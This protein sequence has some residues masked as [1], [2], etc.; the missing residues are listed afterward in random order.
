MKLKASKTIY[1]T[2]TNVTSNTAPLVPTI[3]QQWVDTT[4]ANPTFKEWDGESWTEVNFNI[5]KVDPE[6]I[7]SIK[8]DIQN[9]VED[10]NNSKE[11]IQSALDKSQEAIDKAGLNE[12]NIENMKTDVD[13]AIKNS[14]DA[15]SKSEQAIEESQKLSESVE[16]INTNIEK[17]DSNIGDINTNINKVNESIFDIENEMLTMGENIFPIPT[18]EGE[19]QLSKF[20]HT[21]DNDSKVFITNNDYKEG[22]KEPFIEL[23]TP[24]KIKNDSDRILRIYGNT[25]GNRDL[26]QRKEFEFPIYSGQKFNIS[27]DFRKTFVNGYATVGLMIYDAYSGGTL[28]KWLSKGYKDIDE[29][30]KRVNAT[31]E[32]PEGNYKFGKFFV[33]YQGAGSDEIY[34]DFDNVYITRADVSQTL[35]EVSDGKIKTLI[36]E[37]G[38]TNQRLETAEGSIQKIESLEGSNTLVNTVNGMKQQIQDN[39]GNITTIEANVNGIQTQVQDNKQNISEVTQTAEG[40][41]TEVS[42]AKGDISTLKQTA[43][44]L[45]TRV[46][47]NE[48]NISTLTQTSS[49]LRSDIE[50]A[51]GDISSLQQTALGIQT[52]VEAGDNVWLTPTFENTKLSEYTTAMD[53]WTTIY[54]TDNGIQNSV[55]EVRKYNEPFKQQN[56]SLKALRIDG[57]KTSNVNVLQKPEYNIKIKPGDVFDVSFDFIKTLNGSISVGFKLFREDGTYTWKSIVVGNNF[58]T[59]GSWRHFDGQLELPTNSNYATAQPYVAYNKTDSDEKNYLY[60]DN[61]VIKRSS[62]SQVGQYSQIT[63]TAENIQATVANKADSSTVT[64]LANDI[65]SK[66]SN[67]EFNSYKSQTANQ[68]SSIVENSVT[69]TELIQTENSLTEKIS[70]VDGKIATV[71]KTA[72]DILTTISDPTT[73]LDA[74]YKKVESATGTLTEIKNLEGSSSIVQTVNGLNTTVESK[75]DKSSV[76]QLATQV[77]TVVESQDSINKQ[78]QTATSNISSLQDSQGKTNQRLETVE[79]NIQQISEKTDDNTT[80]INQVKSTANSNTQTITDTKNKLTQV[81][82]S[83]NGVKTQVSSL[84]Q[85]GVNLFP[86]GI[87]YDSKL[88]NYFYG[89]P[90]NGRFSVV[91]K[92]E[93]DGGTN[94]GSEKCLKIISTTTNEVSLRVNSFIPCKAGDTL[95]I[96]FDFFNKSGVTNIKLTARMRYNDGKA[97]DWLSVSQPPKTSQKW[98][99]FNGE[100][101]IPKNVASVQLMIGTNKSTSDS[102]VYVDNILV[103]STEVSSTEFNQTKNSISLIASDSNSSSYFRVTADKIYAQSRDFVLDS[104]VQVSAGFTLTAD[105]IKSKT[106]TG[107]NVTL[108]LDTGVYTTIN[109]S[110]QSQ[111]ILA[112]GGIQSKNGTKLVNIG[113][114]S[115]SYNEIGFGI[116]LKDNNTEKGVLAFDNNSFSVSTDINSDYQSTIGIGSNRF[117]VIT[118]KNLGNRSMIRMIKSGSSVD[119][120]NVSEGCA[121]NVTWQDGKG[122]RIVI[123]NNRPKIYSNDENHIDLGPGYQDVII[124]NN[125]TISVHETYVDINFGGAIR[126][127]GKS[128]LPDGTPTFYFGTT[129]GKGGFHF[130]GG[131]PYITMGG[132]TYAFNTKYLTKLTANYNTGE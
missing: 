99:Q 76:T 36:T 101:K 123:D 7:G 88:T 45:Q 119:I 35:V 22:V 63:Q 38:K 74:T 18:F 79:G 40:L 56:P 82:T 73:G 55:T 130:T 70:T 120:G 5:E 69:K 41:K 16:N 77:S 97:D 96:T 30:W 61:I 47:D 108:N 4:E 107:K 19:V 33:S 39:K 32:I 3:G 75:A 8:S 126:R 86:N 84:T 42:T 48:E 118:G 114:G 25:S 111:T 34:V 93:S 15:I 102:V 13:T 54:I 98:E 57:N 59:G 67:E 1:K 115:N 78:I 2:Q 72:N 9:A 131:R 90:D 66:V 127:L 58:N 44:G 80:L 60:I 124:K 125:K 132:T 53:D 6:T 28:K 29:N 112:D 17:I 105:K 116:Q 11:Q 65:S 83:L 14:S 50:T 110:T 117:E 49:G 85:S 26:S 87:F 64:Q 81:E 27:F 113:F 94:Y 129:D 24:Y 20:S 43:Q 95:S 109:S 21:S 106:L 92:G 122:G 128:T 10:I 68:I 31:V 91:P 104:N 71:S 62:G 52:R 46:Q 51:K 12:E 37:Q 100:I 23:N 89:V 103:N 121:T